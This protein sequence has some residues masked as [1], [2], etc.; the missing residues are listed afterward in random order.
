[1]G[2]SVQ[3]STVVLGPTPL[4]C[5]LP[6]RAGRQDDGGGP[7]LSPRLPCTLGDLW[8]TL[9]TTHS[10][11]LH[12]LPRDKR[13]VHVPGLDVATLPLGLRQGP[14]AAGAVTEGAGGNMEDNNITINNEERNKI[15]EKTIC[16]L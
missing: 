15:E 2:E 3:Y 12:C 1:M 11:S 14:H 13:I 6:S 8:V 9:L 7:A 16:V 4:G 5:G 10:V